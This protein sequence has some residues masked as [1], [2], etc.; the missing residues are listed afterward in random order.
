MNRRGLLQSLGAVVFGSAAAAFSPR[1]Y[2]PAPTASQV[3]NIAEGSPL[4]HKHVIRIVVEDVRK[5]GLI[6][7]AIMKD[8]L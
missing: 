2:A 4:A 8:L 3:I 5:G 7:D 6:R 1:R